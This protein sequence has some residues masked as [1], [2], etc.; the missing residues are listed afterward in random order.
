[1]KKTSRGVIP[2][3]GDPDA[4][5][6]SFRFWVVLSRRDIGRALPSALAAK[7]GLDSAESYEKIKEYR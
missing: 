5:D 1:M 6:P 4:G 7:H 3:T 2:P